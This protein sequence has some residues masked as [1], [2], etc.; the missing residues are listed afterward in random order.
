[1]AG[2]RADGV[3]APA[4]LDGAVNGTASFRA[5][6][7]QVLAPGLRPGGAVVIDSLGSHRVKGA[8]EAT[9]A[10]GARPLLPPPCGPDLNPAEQL[11]AGPKALPRAAARRAAARRAAARQAAASPT[12]SGTPPAARP[13]PSARTSACRNRIANCGYSPP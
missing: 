4:V 10:A 11:F 5:C 9:E 3:A 6:A 8:R 12:A 2:L 1:V 13:T 7:E